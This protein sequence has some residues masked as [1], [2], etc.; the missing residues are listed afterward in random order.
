MT[1]RTGLVPDAS[2]RYAALLKSYRSVPSTGLHQ[3]Y[4]R[5]H[6]SS[7]LCYRFPPPRGVALPKPTHQVWE[8]AQGQEQ[9]PW[10]SPRTFQ[11]S[12]GSPHRSVCIKAMLQFT[13][14]E[15]PSRKTRA[16]WIIYT[17]Y[18]SSVA[19]VFSHKSAPRTN[20]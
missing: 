16:P 7:G 10:D 17:G 2:R 20:P 14:A 4:R 15:D 13:R 18:E 19:L 1:Q 3:Y 8:W 9:A 12:P 5:Q 11:G 6:H